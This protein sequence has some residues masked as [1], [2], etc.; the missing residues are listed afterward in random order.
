M[1]PILT[2]VI[3]LSAVAIAFM[4][5]FVDVKVFFTFIFISVS[6]SFFYLW[7]M[8]K[9]APSPRRSPPRSSYGLQQVHPSTVQMEASG[10]SDGGE[11]GVE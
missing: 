3:L 2:T 7:I 8:D 4:I 6:T 10:A 5:A 1:D 9:L 11:T